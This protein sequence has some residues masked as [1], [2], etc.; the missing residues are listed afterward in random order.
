VLQRRR[1]GHL[2]AARAPGPAPH[3]MQG[4]PPRCL[5]FPA[6]MGARRARG[7]AKTQR[8]PCGGPRCGSSPAR[9]ARAC[10]PGVTA[11]RALGRP[12][13]EH[14]PTRERRGSAT[15]RSRPC[16]GSACLPEGGGV[17]HLPGSA[18]L[19]HEATPA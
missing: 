6:A 19:R 12:R 3:A 9:L 16:G 2:R 1:G 5:G 13:A 10:R 7:S 18:R 15:A 14:E 4:P 8:E 11:W 17:L